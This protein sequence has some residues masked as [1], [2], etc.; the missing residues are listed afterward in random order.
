MED[1]NPELRLKEL[2]IELPNAPNP[3]ANY[4]NGVKLEI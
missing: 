1:Y 3:V 2:N 4:V